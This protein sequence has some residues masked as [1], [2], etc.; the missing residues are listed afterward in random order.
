MCPKPRSSA[1]EIGGI[2]VAG[3]IFIISLVLIIARVLTIGHHFRH[4]YRRGF[5]EVFG[6]EIG[7]EKV[8][9]ATV[10]GYNSECHDKL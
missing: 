7:S 5:H 8:R 4:R 9:A 1:S 10:M 6:L 2:I 3:A